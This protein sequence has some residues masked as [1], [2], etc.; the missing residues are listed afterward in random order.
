MKRE[1]SAE[2]D[3]LRLAEELAS[4]SEEAAKQEWVSLANEGLL[5]EIDKYRSLVKLLDGK[6]HDSS[7]VVEGSTPEEN[8][9]ERK[10]K[11]QE[12][13]VDEVDPSEWQ[14]P[15]HCIPIQAD[16]T[17]YDWKSLYE[18][19]KFDVV[20]MDPPW[21]LATANPTRGVA[22]GYGQLTN[23]DIMA[24]P[25]PKLQE[26][27]L[28]FVWVINSSYDFVVGLFNRWGYKVVD[29]VVWVKLTVNRRL[30]KSHGFY[31]QHAKEV[32]LVGLKGDWP[33]KVRGSVGSDVILSERRGQSQ[34]PQ[35]I[36][37]LIEE[38]VPNGKYLEI[39]ARKN[40]L[41]NHWVSVGNEVC[42]TLKM[43][44]DPVAVKSSPCASKKLALDDAD[45]SEKL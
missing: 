29:E 28:L 37:E 1:S 18:T 44:D 19:T 38:L 26:N 3:K 22:L 13:S 20:M 25:I 33:E 23:K 24:L 7:E 21:V 8:D 5:G 36:Y 35:E 12:I 2:P 17:L 41:R 6:L 39:F 31:L 14:V 9:V 43:D 30:A 34:K 32:C 40:N 42:G 45:I 10:A 11:L 16:V 27:G 4:Q 15:P